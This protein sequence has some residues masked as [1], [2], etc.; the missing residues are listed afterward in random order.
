VYEIMQV[1]P[2]VQELVT[3]RT[4]TEQIRRK[5]LE[6]G[7][8]SLKVDALRLVRE[9]TTSVAEVRAVVG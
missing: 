2:E 3:Q 4:A 7:M 9:H 1:T 8:L 5:A 6:Q